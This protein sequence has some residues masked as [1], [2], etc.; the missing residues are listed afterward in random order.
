MKKFM[1]DIRTLAALLMASATFA[2]C[3][4]DDS[5]FTADQPA[6]PAGKQ[7]YTMT[8]SAT[9]GDNTTRG[10]SLDDKTLNAVWKEGETV[11]VYNAS[12]EK[13]AELAP[14][15]T[16][17]ASTTLTGEITG[18]MPNVDDALTLKFLSP[19]YTSQD[20]TLA[21]IES[22]CDYATASVTVSSVSGSN[23]TTDDANF[24][25]QQ[26]I[27]KFTLVDKANVTTKLNP[28]TF[29]ITW[30]SANN[31]EEVVKLTGIP[32]A[33]YD[34]N[35]DGVLYVALPAI[36]NKLVMLAAN[37]GDDMYTMEKKGVTFANGQYYAI[38][39]KTEKYD[40]L[41][42]PL[43]FLI[44]DMTKYTD[45]KFCFTNK[46]SGSVYYTINGGD[47]VEIK[48]GSESEFAVEPG[49]KVAFYGDN[50]T[51]GASTDNNCS[52]CG[53][54]SSQGYYYIY[55]NIM[56]L[57]S[58]EDYAN[59]T[60]LTN[61]YTFKSM[62]S[63]S[64]NMRNHPYKKIMLPATTLT[65]YCYESMFANCNSLE[66][67]PDLPAKNG[68]QYCYQYMFANCYALKSIKCLL[69]ST[70]Y[71]SSYFT[72]DWVPSSSADSGTIFT[73]S[74]CKDWTNGSSGIRS[75]WTRIDVE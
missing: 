32:D 42:T 25:N 37:V 71:R 54:K 29:T 10:L 19:D 26:A 30:F 75:G 65:P 72:K 69:K 67:A 61:N 64:Y 5:D 15:T 33:T 55:G 9:K 4:S 39:A 21:Y 23:I 47:R 68:A 38:T 11:K 18:T 66:E 40:A 6:Q 51:Y 45:G 8:V 34:A 70:R 7:V 46:A 20:G 28:T 52:F 50:A 49:D 17:T 2:A 58:S 44:I 59:A 63:D 56:S 62:F 22:H 74:E 60:V 73:N 24:V 36:S 16:G 41:N 14:T 43:T 13:I 1:T 53:D 3:S 48:A 31:K 12:N 35:G 57:V 27:V